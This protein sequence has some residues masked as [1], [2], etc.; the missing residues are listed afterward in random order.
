MTLA[1][2]KDDF[3]YSLARSG[4]CTS[5]MKPVHSGEGSI[6][7]RSTP[8]CGCKFIYL[9]CVYYLNVNVSVPC[10][11]S[12]NTCHSHSCQPHMTS[13]LMSPMNSLP[14][15]PSV[16][17]CESNLPPIPPA[18]D[19]IPTRYNT[20]VRCELQPDTPRYNFSTFCE[21]GDTLPKPDDFASLS[22]TKADESVG[23]GTL[24]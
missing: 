3:T 22:R 16:C 14:P 10:N 18:M 24:V 5:A 23:N 19:P 17:S 6:R 13:H 8:S 9:A 20:V 15:P 4:Y 12:Y 7:S 21:R 11:A 1:F 2:H